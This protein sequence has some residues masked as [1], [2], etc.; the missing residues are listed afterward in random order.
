MT[1]DFLKP[2][3]IEFQAVSDNMM[4]VHR[5]TAALDSQI[6]STLAAMDPAIAL[7]QGDGMLIAEAHAKGV[8]PLRKLA[9]ASSESRAL[10]YGIS[11]VLRKYGYELPVVRTRG[12]GGGR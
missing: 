8:L 1:K 2:C 4:E 7:L 3:P 10:H 9:L 12:P 5:L 6:Q 11:E